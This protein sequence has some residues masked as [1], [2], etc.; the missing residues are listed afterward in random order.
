MMGKIMLLTIPYRYGLIVVAYRS[1]ALL[2]PTTFLR[3]SA[4]LFVFLFLRVCVCVL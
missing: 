4:F 2:L 1:V 3:T